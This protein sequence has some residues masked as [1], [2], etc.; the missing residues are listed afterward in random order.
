MF[1]VFYYENQHLS[2][3]LERNFAK[4]RIVSNLY[5]FN[6]NEMFSGKKPKSSVVIESGEVY[7]FYEKISQLLD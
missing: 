7:A 6:L 3:Y 4:M 1:L 5:K 2:H